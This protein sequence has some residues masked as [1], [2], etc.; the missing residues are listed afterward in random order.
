ME[1]RASTAALQRTRLWAVFL[2]SPH[3]SPHCLR[4]SSQDRLHV[5]LG[6]PAR[7]YPCSAIRVIL[8][9]GF[10]SVG[11][12]HFH[13]RRAICW[14]IGSWFSL[15]HRFL[16]QIFS[17]QR[18]RRIWHKQRFMNVWSLSDRVFVTLQ[19]SEPYRSTA[20]TLQL[21]MRSLFLVER[22]EDPLMGFRIIKACLALAILVLKS[23]SA[24][25]VVET[26]LPR[27]VKKFTSL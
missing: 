24:P 15:C 4:S 25:P 10:L 14:V 26:T 22:V 27:Y 12:I 19:V 5:V 1:H 13:F 9:D 16:L 3:E 2:I 17:G 8:S 6:R 23:S 7:L 11:P 21:K 18:M 20:L